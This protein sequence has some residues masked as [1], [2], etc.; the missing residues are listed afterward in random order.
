MEE[1]LANEILDASNNRGGAVKKGRHA[2]HG[3]SEQGVCALSLVA[4]NVNATASS[5]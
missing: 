4:G 5:T 3:G 1:K 2:P